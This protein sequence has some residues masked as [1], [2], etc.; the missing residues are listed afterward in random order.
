MR[1][2]LQCLVSLLVLGMC[3]CG[4]SRLAGSMSKKVIKKASAIRA[5]G[6]C[7]R[8]HEQKAW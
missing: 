7:C 6:L 3:K 4:D 2:L 8:D 5:Q 1:G